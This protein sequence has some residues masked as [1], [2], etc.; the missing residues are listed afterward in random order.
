MGWGRESKSQ[1][2]QIFYNQDEKYIKVSKQAVKVEV[3]MRIKM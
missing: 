1:Y 3:N 2:K